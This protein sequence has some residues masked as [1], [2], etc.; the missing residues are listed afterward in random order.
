[1]GDPKDN[2]EV[3]TGTPKPGDGPK[4]EPKEEGGG[5]G[6]GHIDPLQG[7]SPFLPQDQDENEDDPKG[8]PKPD[9]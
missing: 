4:I 9:D 5:G 3:D 1:M 6:G 2:N 8:K 7:P